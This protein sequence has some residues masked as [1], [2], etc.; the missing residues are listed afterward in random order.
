MA[1]R[2]AELERKKARLAAMREEKKRKEEDKK[3]KE[4]SVIM[5]QLIS[6]FSHGQSS[7]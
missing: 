2:K 5:I 4:V 3:K 7:M 6:D 1:D